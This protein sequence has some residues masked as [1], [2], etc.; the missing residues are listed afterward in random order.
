MTCVSPCPKCGGKQR[1]HVVA[2]I[3]APADMYGQLH[4][5]NLRE[6]GVYLMGV[7]WETADFMCE[8]CGCLTKDG[9]GNYVTR[10]EKENQK[11][12]EKNQELKRENESLSK[13]Y[14]EKNDGRF[15]P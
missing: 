13:F 1:M 8:V 9:Y 11:L 12:K 3:S 14:M 5:A 2:T 15:A 4:K 10:L 6:K 7:N